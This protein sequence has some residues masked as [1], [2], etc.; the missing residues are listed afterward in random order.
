[1]DNLKRFSCDESFMSCSDQGFGLRPRAR[2][3]SDVERTC[4]KSFTTA[5]YPELSCFH[6]FYLANAAKW[7]DENGIS[8]RPPNPDLDQ[9][10]SGAAAGS[11][12]AGVPAPPLDTSGSST[13]RGLGPVS[14]AP[15]FAVTSA[16]TGTPTSGG[17]GTTANSTTTDFSTSNTTTTLTTDASTTGTTQASTTNPSTNT[18][19][20]TSTD[21]AVTNPGGLSGGAIA[22]IVIGVL[23]AVALIAALV[24][25]FVIRGGSEGAYKNFDQT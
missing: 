16:N 19:G 17:N 21:G 23:V 24:Y 20:P 10:I 22:G 4:E 1:L 3:C 5:G 14:D 12:P 7:V 18:V 2:L 25:W 8:V 13:G 6:S 15:E 11:A 9:T